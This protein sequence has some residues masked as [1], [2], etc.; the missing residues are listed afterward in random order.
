MFLQ[1]QHVSKVL[2]TMRTR[3]RQDFVAQTPGPP[4]GKSGILVFLATAMARSLL[5]GVKVEGTST[6]KIGALLLR[7]VRV[8]HVALQGDA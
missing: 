5:R 7:F 1:L 4:A 6:A 8:K 3:L 2:S